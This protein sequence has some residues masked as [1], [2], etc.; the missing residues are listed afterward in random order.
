MLGIYCRISREKEAGKDR[1]IADQKALGIELAQK[2]R[3]EYKV[4]IDEGYSGT[5][6]NIK[7]RPAFS[8]ND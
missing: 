8:K 7:D 6:E 1:S 5:L 2:H 3:T 4:Y